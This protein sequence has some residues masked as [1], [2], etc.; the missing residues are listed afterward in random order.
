[1][2]VC[3]EKGLHQKL[4][5]CIST[6][7]TR[8]SFKAISLSYSLSW[9]WVCHQQ[10]VTQT[11]ISSLRSHWI[12]FSAYLWYSSIWTSHPNGKNRKENLSFSIVIQKEIAICICSPAKWAFLQSPLAVL[13]IVLPHACATML[14]V[15][16]ICDHITVYVLST[17][18]LPVFLWK[19]PSEEL[20]RK[21]LFFTVYWVSVRIFLMHLSDSCTWH[22]L[23]PIY[24]S[25]NGKFT[26]LLWPNCRDDCVK[27]LWNL[28]KCMVIMKLYEY[29]TVIGNYHIILV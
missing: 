14:E 4:C 12:L 25:D 18:Q 5:Y 3:V 21:V 27:G 2:W 29:I 10:L 9:T 15:S 16:W 11:V 8:I 19:N 24:I 13:P 7:S 1:M 17:Q 20:K 6:Q 26:V 22:I 28:Y 23:F